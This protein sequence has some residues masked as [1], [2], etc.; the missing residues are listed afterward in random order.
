MLG[1]V[2]QR[3]KC[4]D[5]RHKIIRYRATNA[6][7]RKFDYILLGTRLNTAGAENFAINADITEFVDDQG[8]AT[9]FRILKNMADQ[10]RLS[11]TQKPGNDGDRNFG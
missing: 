6:P 4:L 1:A 10:R 9:P 8:E 2:L 7:I 11:G 3:E 5:S